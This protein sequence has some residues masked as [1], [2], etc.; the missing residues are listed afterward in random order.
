M[1]PVCMCSKRKTGGKTFEYVLAPESI[2]FNE[3]LIGFHKLLAFFPSSLCRTLCITF[4]INSLGMLSYNFDCPLRLLVT[5]TT[6]QSINS[7]MLN[8]PS[9]LQ[10]MKDEEKFLSDEIKI[11]KELFLLLLFDL[12]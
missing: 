8:S 6:K 3:N 1:F 7:L 4:N 10:S 12:L 9:V 11:N 2:E 5:S